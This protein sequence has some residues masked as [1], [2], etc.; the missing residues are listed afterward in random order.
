MSLG[1][2]IRSLENGALDSPAAMATLLEGACFDEPWIQ[3]HLPDPLP[4][5]GYSRDVLYCG[6]RFEIVLAT[7]PA[8]VSTL[9]HNHGAL[10]SHGLVLVLRGDIFNHIYRRGAD[11]EVHLV[12]EATH[13]LGEMI[14]VPKGLLHSMGNARREGHAVS[15]HIYAPKI[16]DVSYWDPASLKPLE[17]MRQVG[18][19]RK[20]RVESDVLEPAAGS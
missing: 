20:V 16:V 9:V 3:A 14:A 11:G 18:V 4:T 17:S 8:G 13:R 1:S 10:E 2:I 19:G 12:R 15:L 7:W 6:E 5:E